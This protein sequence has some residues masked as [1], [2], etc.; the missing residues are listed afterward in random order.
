MMCHATLAFLLA[1]CYFC[2]VEQFRLKGNPFHPGD[3]PVE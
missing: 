2:L 3:V 1:N